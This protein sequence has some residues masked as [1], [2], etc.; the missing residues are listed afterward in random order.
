[1]GHARVAISE[2]VFRDPETAKLMRFLN[3][4]LPVDTVVASDPVLSSMIKLTTRQARRWR[5]RM[6]VRAGL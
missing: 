4:S 3:R 5:G 2:N 6:P 1:M